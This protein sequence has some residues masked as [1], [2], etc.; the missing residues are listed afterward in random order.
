M[1]LFRRIFFAAVLAGAVAG[2]VYAGLQQWR[3]VPLILQ[4][5]TFETGGHSHGGEA[6]HTHEDGTTHTHDTAVEADAE[7]WAPADGIERGFYTVL[8]TTLASLGFALVIGAVSV[9]AGIPITLANGVLWGLGGFLAFS[10]APAFGLAPELPGM[11]AADLAT[12]QIW[13]WGTAIATGVAVL[14]IAKFR[15]PGAI[16]ICVLIAAVPH[17]IGA[18]AAPGEHSG[19]PAHLATSY[20]AAA[21]GTAMVFWLVLGVGFGWA[22]DKF[23]KGEAA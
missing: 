18:P 19:V 4:A 7:P 22:N 5:E 3:V 16:A 2:L 17:L 14:G 21:L 8:A 11:P 9:L 10:L 6:V 20:A 23:G 1:E 15:T 12:R 13:W